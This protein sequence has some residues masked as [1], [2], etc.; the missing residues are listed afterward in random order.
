MKTHKDV[1]VEE[2]VVRHRPAFAAALRIGAVLVGL[3]LI[4]AFY[5]L[6]GMLLGNAV[7]SALFA[8]V[9]IGIFM[10]FRYLWLEYEYSFFSGEVD[11]DRI[12]GKRKRSRL[13]SFSCRDIELM[14]PY[15]PEYDH[16]LNGQFQR[17][18]D[19]RGSG[20]GERDWFII[21]RAQDGSRYIIALSPSERLLDAF[22]QYV[23]RGR[24]KE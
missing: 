23:R 6:T 16:E 14:A 5:Y 9:C 13:L 2:L 21:C 11:I 4:W 15:S 17:K 7:F 22:R 3:L 1:F 19:V 10:V 8:L 24:M 12:L 18:L 20:R